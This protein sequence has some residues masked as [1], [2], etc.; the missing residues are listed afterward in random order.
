[1]L[2]K[3]KKMTNNNEQ[4]I[5]QFRFSI[6]IPMRWNDLDGLGYVNNIYYFEYFQIIRGEYFPAVSD[7][8]WRKNMFVIAHIECD[9]LQE[10]TLQSI[11]PTVKA[12]T[13]SISNKSFEMEY[14]ITSKAKDGSDIIHAK[15]K[16]INVMVDIVAKK[17]VQIPDWL[18]NK[19]TE[20]EPASIHY[21]YPTKTDL[22]I[23]IIQ[24]HLAA[25]NQ[26]ITRNKNKTPIEK[27]DK[28]FNYYQKLSKR[29]HVCI[30]G[31]MASDVY[32]LEELLRN[33][34]L[35]FSNAVIDWATSILEE[36]IKQQ[37]FKPSKNA[38]ITA[39]LIVSNL[40]ALVQISRL[41]QD[42]NNFD[43]Y[44]EE[45]KSNILL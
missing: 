8:D 43:I 29:N 4:T 24:Q 14:L 36:G 22:G 17:S 13:S 21:H 19:L 34:L 41:E 40:M 32:T 6:P 15:G 18:L 11:S 10:L 33:E 5:K 42:K 2:I 23:A 38:R 28:L 9:F 7:W 45:L 35:S 39:K 1:M 26:T 3:Q 37:L 12:R 16:S 31:A 44:I 25:L 27:L 20:Y 30:V